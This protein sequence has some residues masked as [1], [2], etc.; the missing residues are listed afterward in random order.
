[1]KRW[2]LGGISLVLAPVLV[3]LLLAVLA[4]FLPV[5]ADRSPVAQGIRI[6]VAS[7]G[8][9]TDLLLPRSAAEVNWR[10]EFPASDFPAVPDAAPYLGFGWGDRDFYMATRR[11]ADVSVALVWRALIGS[12]PTV[13]KVGNYVEPEPGERVVGLSLSEEEYHRLVRFVR[14]SFVRVAEQRPLLYRNSGYGDHDAF[15]AAHG[16]YSAF[17]TCNEWVADALRE[18]G[19]TTPRW[20]P[21]AWPILY[22]IRIRAG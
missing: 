22:W 17:Q 16:R 7:N 5:N 19:V 21:F 1:M 20:S 18:A 15:Y 2:F 13:V 11:W 14:Q 9:H 6:Y 8:V 3:Y 10:D 12:G 4:A